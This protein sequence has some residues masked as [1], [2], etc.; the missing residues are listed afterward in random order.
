MLADHGLVESM[1]RR[2]NPFD[3]TKAESS[4]KTLT[5]EAVSLNDY[6]TFKPVSTD[7]PRLASDNQALVAAWRPA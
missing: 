5:V 7:L 3:N 2:G 1:S 4:I 6:E